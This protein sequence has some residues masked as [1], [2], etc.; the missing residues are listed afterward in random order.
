MN[1]TAV[2]PSPSVLSDLAGKVAVVVGGGREST[3]TAAALASAGA[4]V[5]LAAADEPAILRAARAI[6]SAGGR[7][8]A[9]P[10]DIAEP[11]ALG[12][13]VDVT[14]DAFGR[15]DVAVNSPGPVRRAGQIAA[16]GCRAVY[17][18]MRYEVP[19]LLRSGGGVVVNSALAPPGARPEDAECV[20]GLTRA[21]ALDHADH[22]VR[23]NAVAYG[24]GTPE[25]F[26]AA[27]LWLSSEGAA[28]VNG[29][30]VP[31]GLRPAL[32]AA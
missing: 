16:P 20:I 17:L 10:T 23:I 15:L 32:A 1:A 18:A 9:I 25:D 30:A 21:A 24:P 13:L 29:A 14:A 2:Q 5:T 3:A 11:R 22:D 7:A 8:L 26:A 28:Q 27:A 6:Q 12:R 4:A 19:A 31:V